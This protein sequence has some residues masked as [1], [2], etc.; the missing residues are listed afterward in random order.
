MT[1]GGDVEFYSEHIA[2]VVTSDGNE[3][4][5]TLIEYWATGPGE[6]EPVVHDG[7]V[8]GLLGELNEV[9][10]AVNPAGGGEAIPGTK[11]V[12]ETDKVAFAKGAKEMR[13]RLAKG[14]LCLGRVSG[15]NL[16][17]TKEALA[18]NVWLKR[19]RMEALLRGEDL[20]TVY[21][22]ESTAEK[23]ISRNETT[24]HWVV[25]NPTSFATRDGVFRQCEEK[26]ETLVTGQVA[27]EGA[28]EAGLAGANVSAKSAAPGWCLKHRGEEL[29]C[30]MCARQKRDRSGASKGGV[31]EP[32][33]ASPGTDGERLKWCHKHSRGFD[34]TVTSGC[35][36]CATTGCTRCGVCSNIF[37]TAVGCMQCREERDK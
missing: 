10:R 11:A 12:K 3:A 28:A 13:K 24:D 26:G 19:L 29:P 5:N 7:R 25:V 32:R 34:A 36:E 31:D 22:D 27:G 21:E 15:P 6:G 9:L 4:V 35:Q 20:S 18:G 1:F 2:E 17:V 23:R 16:V 14:L 33:E 30:T 8:R 37:L